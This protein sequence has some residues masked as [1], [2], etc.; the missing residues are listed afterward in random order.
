MADNKKY[1]Y[2]R[3]TE[4]FFDSE[5]MII[6]ESM[7]DGY[8]Y[9]NILL[10]LY[11][12]SLKGNGRL[13]FNDRIPYNP[14]ILAQIT[15]HSVGV[16]EKALQLFQDLGL[17]EVLD[18]GA[19]YML[20]IQN[21]IGKS[22]TE[23][24]R[25]REYRAQI[26]SEKTDTDKCPDKS[27]DK[28]TPEIEIEK[29]IEI[30]ERDNISCAPEAARKLSK[31]EKQLDTRREEFEK[32]YAIYPKKRGKAKAYE[33]YCGYVGK[34]RKLSGQNYKLLP[35]DIY[36]AVKNYVEERQREGTELEYYKNFDTFMNKTVIDY[37]G[38]GDLN[39]NIDSERPRMLSGNEIVKLIQAGQT[40]DQ[41]ERQMPGPFM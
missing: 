10:K 7:P 22:S 37:L 4:N 28:S 12:K 2:L 40:S 19:I 5:A 11:T 20:D 36:I 27:T 30:I 24:D 32:V 41:I 18:N 6:L 29:E 21:F 34:G 3:L 17:I 25:K 33:F 15:R 31:E 39:E 16:M 35:E 13:M 38:K 26:E 14:T 23:A 1:Y 9:S 8:L